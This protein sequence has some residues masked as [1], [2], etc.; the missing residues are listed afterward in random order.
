MKHIIAKWAITTL[1]LTLA[2]P[3]IANAND[4][5]S[6]ALELAGQDKFSEALA[7]L[8]QADTVTQS[9]YEHRFL[10]SRILS[11]AG[12]YDRAQREI[13]GLMAEFPGNADVELAAG[14]LAYYQNDLNTAE[15]YYQAVLT[16]NPN[17]AD[18]SRGLENV[19]KARQ[20]RLSEGRHLWRIDGG[21]GFSG[22]DEDNISEWDEQYLRAEYVPDTLAYH[23]QVQRYNR[24]DETDVQIIGG[25]SDAVRGGWDW[26]VELGVTPDADFRP[27]F[28]AGGRV[29]RAIDTGTG[30]VFYPS[31][32]YRYDDYAAGDIQTVQPSLTTYLD[33]GVILTGRLI[34]TFQEVEDDQIGWLV[35]GRAP[36]SDKIQINVGYA[37]APE[38]ING[39]AIDTKSVFGGITYSMREDLDLHV[40]LARDDREDS[41]V[42]SSVNVGF[43]YKR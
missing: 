23:G 4:I 24:F 32:S 29:G 38:A 19:R 20:G 16:K 3:S 18:A 6:R 43:T 7:L 42:R 26:G 8:S 28:S 9:S 13:N 5:N 40:N 37:Q 31:L 2:L 10:K 34:G 15:R 33:N 22:F 21:L 25:I 36:V 30:T 39:I 35:Q 12:Q 41:Y 11:W 17:Y 27:D 1:A 14:N